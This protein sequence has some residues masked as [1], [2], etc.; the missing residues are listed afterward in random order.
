VNNSVPAA[1]PLQHCSRLSSLGRLKKIHHGIFMCVI[2]T[3]Y[4]PVHRTK[5]ENF[6]NNNFLK[7]TCSEE[8]GEVTSLWGQ[9]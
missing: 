1:H 9:C 8:I 6:S 3:D 2:K 7:Q 4:W 5:T